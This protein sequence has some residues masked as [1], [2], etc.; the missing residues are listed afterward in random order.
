MVSGDGPRLTP[1]QWEKE[2]ERRHD[3]RSALF[4]FFGAMAGA[5]AALIVGKMTLDGQREQIE[6]QLEQQRVTFLLNQRAAAYADLFN[7]FNDLR[8]IV[9]QE[10]KSYLDAPDSADRDLML[11]TF[12][13]ARELFRTINK[14]TTSIRLLGPAD[15][16]KSASTANQLHGDYLAAARALLLRGQG[17]AADIE[18]LLE[19]AESEKQRFFARAQEVVGYDLE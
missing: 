6:G 18:V 11:E 17:S 3:R 4:G 13:R 15:V 1:E 14:Q 12:G 16:Y 19:E 5:G 7:S 2:S 10:I 8:I 9:E